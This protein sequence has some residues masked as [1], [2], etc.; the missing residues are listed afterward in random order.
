[1]LTYIDHDE[2]SYINLLTD[3]SMLFQVSGVYFPGF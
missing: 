3:C 2:L 1:M